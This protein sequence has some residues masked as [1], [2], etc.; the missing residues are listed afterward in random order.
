VTLTVKTTRRPHLIVRLAQSVRETLGYDLPIVAYD[1]GPNDYSVEIREQVAEYPLLEYVVSKNQDLGISRGRNLAIKMVKTKYFFL[2]DDDILFIKSTNLE[3]LVEIL[4]TSDA[5]VASAA[6]EGMSGLAGYFDFGYFDKDTH[7]R[8]MQCKYGA[9][10]L[11]NQTIPN[12]P[13]CVRCEITSN[14][15]LART[16]EIL[17]IGG[18]DPELMIFEHMDVFIRL[19]AGGMK[20]ALCPEVELKHARP[21]T[22]EERGEGYVEKRRRGGE[23]FVLQLTCNKF[24]AL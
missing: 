23:R 9:C 16:R 2:L 4:D 18:W 17:D 22:L 10:A 3:K 13:S 11:N 20:V 21:Q 19:K 5:T 15:F 14:V 6:Y 1:D 7:K 8:T 12:H 24:V